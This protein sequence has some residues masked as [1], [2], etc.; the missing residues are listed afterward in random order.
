MPVAARAPGRRGPSAACSAAA[1]CCG[2]RRC[3]CR[4]AARRGTRCRAGGEPTSS[5]SGRRRPS[6]AAGPRVR[7]HRSPT[8][9]GFGRS[10]TTATRGCRSG[11][12]SSTRL[13]YPLLDLTTTLDPHF[14]IAYRFGAI[15]LA[16]PFPDGPG[17]GRPGHRAARAGPRARTRRSGSTRRTRASSTTG[18]CR[19]TRPR[20][21]GSTARRASTGAP[22]WLRSMA[23]TTLAEGGDRQSSRQLWQQL[24][25]TSEQRVGE[26]QR[27]AEARAA[28]RARS[29]GRAGRRWSAATPT[30]PAG[31]R[32]SWADLG[33]LRWLRG[34]P[35]DPSRHAVRTR[36][37]ASRAAWPGRDVAALSA[38]RPR[39][40][41]RR[42]RHHDDRLAAAF[43]PDCSGWRLGSFLNVCIYR[44][45]LEQSLAFPASRC[46]VC[47]R[48]SAGSRTCRSLAWLVAAAG[49]AGRATRRIS[50][51]YPLVEALHRRDVR[52][53]R[54]GSTGRDGCSSRG[55]C[56]AARSSCC[57][58]STCDHR[59][60]PNVITVR[61]T[62]IGFILSFVTPPGWVSSLI[63]LVHRRPD[64][65]GCSPRPT[66]A[67]ARS[68][69]SA[70][71]T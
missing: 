28:R 24:Y 48:G 43:W 47:N 53:G 58:S 10:S 51:V 25:E 62:I 35:A 61:G 23:A 52:R 1:R 5:T 56:S 30:R 66:S 3:R 49:S 22:W 70:W 41:G 32:D 18:G 20:P 21:R 12:T 63:G 15:F 7:R 59:I 38:S 50:V 69:D 8:S 34:V 27:P 6:R 33:A 44:L 26:E 4:R 19:T 54:R 36:P 14:T 42:A 65:A 29:D 71:A 57:S 31:L 60:L 9:T 13:L 39:S 68:R 67:C 55:C 16:E 46:T 11:R 64:S 45:P 2:A 40:R 37:D 17:P